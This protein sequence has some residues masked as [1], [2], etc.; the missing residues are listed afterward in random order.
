LQYA[1]AAGAGPPQ[2][3]W[4]NQEKAAAEKQAARTKARI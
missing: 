4:R 1:D 3:W 2:F